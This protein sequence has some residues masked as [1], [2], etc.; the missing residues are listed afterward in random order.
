MSSSETPSLGNWDSELSEAVKWYWATRLGQREKQQESKNTAR[1]RRADVLGGKQLDGFAG[2]VED[3]LVEGGVPRGSVVHDH[4]ATLP[5]YYR[6]SKGWDIAVVHKGQLLAAVEFKSIASSF[7]NNLNNRSEEALGSSIDL[8]KAYEEGV[9]EPSPA[10][11]V[12]YF[13]L[14]ADIEG[15]TDYPVQ[16]TSPS[17]P[18]EDAFK[19]ASY[20]KRG[21]LLCLRM[22][23]KRVVNGATFLLSDPEAG[24]DGGYTQPNE[25]LSFHRFARSLTAH[26]ASYI[27]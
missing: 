22:V 19:D 7:G 17:F 21:E 9:F 8:L 4:A 5:G 20:A 14:M 18:A 12:G 25:E 11:W 15:S 2:L 16:I 27:E 13:L 1:G 3:L 23:R 10:P 26:A 24:L 6:A